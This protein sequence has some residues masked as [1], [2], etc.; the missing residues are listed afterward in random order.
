VTRTGCSPCTLAGAVALALAT[1]CRPGPVHRWADGRAVAR[2]HVVRHDHEGRW[3]LFD[4]QGRRLI[5]GTYDK[6]TAV[7]IW[8]TF[9][10]ATGRLVQQHTL[11]AGALH[12]AAATWHGNGAPAS[13]GAFANGQRDGAWLCW[14]PD[15]TLD[16]E[17]TGWYRAGVRAD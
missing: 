7:G 16:P 9:D 3:T 6:G 1:A 4:E 12:G 10:P 2:G 5:T 8:K 17:Q 15:G 11:V 14:R 13:R